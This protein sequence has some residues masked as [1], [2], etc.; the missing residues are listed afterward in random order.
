MAIKKI[1]HEY[2]NHFSSTVPLSELNAQLEKKHLVA[3]RHDVDYDIDI[4]LEMSYWEHREGIRATFFMLPGSNYWHDPDLIDKILQIQDFGH[5]IGVHINVLT[6]WM[7]GRIK[8]PGERLR[9]VLDVFRTA[10]IKTTGVSAH[11][12]PLCYKKSYNNYWIFRELR[13]DIPEREEAGISAEGIPSTGD[14]EPIIYP[15]DH[16]LARDNGDRLSLWSVSMKALE[17]DY[18]AIHIPH[19]QYFSDS[20]GEWKRSPNPLDVD[21]TRGRHQILVHP[22]YWRGTQKLFFFLSTARSGS[23]WLSTVL[24]KASSLKSQHEF[25][26]NHRMVEGNI[27]A[28]KRTADG[29]TDLQSGPSEVMDLLL[30][31][32]PWI[33]EL[34]KDYAEVNVYLERFLTE[35][36]EVFPEAVN[37]HLH[38]HPCDVVRSII[39]RFWYDTPEDNR[40]PHFSVP[41]WN[42]LSQFQQACWYART[43]NEN[44][45]KNCSNRF[46]FEKMVSKPVELNRILDSLDVAFYP[47]LAAP[48]FKKKINANTRNDFPPY[49]EWTRSQRVFYHDTCD[50][51]NKTL[52]YPTRHVFANVLRAIKNL[53]LTSC[54]KSFRSDNSHKGANILNQQPIPLYVDLFASSPSMGTCIEMDNNLLHI[55][56][57][58]GRNA[59]LLFG[60]GNWH[61]INGENGWKAKRAHYYRGNITVKILDTKGTARMICLM[62]DGKGCLIGQRPLVRIRREKD[63]HTFAFRPG[64]ATARFNIAL[65]MPA[66]ELPEEITVKSLSLEMLP[67]RYDS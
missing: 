42:G 44:L 51:V 38:R 22:E 46:C 30:E 12:D 17:L 10:G 36:A 9:Q 59:Y 53:I 23:K 50:D 31:M 11:G 41:G 24:D 66:S 43:V 15:S 16:S 37:V 3:L 19:D 58:E 27:V 62:Y 21:L 45:I 55:S 57:Q 13:P 6:E 60:G 54:Q 40:H 25:L 29:F 64:S 1:Y 48:L 56:P 7:Q 32:R 20:G 26:L 49:R 52:G 14:R 5:E 33:E 39:N 63:L 67:L 34:D 47:R 2:L 8:D 61:T 35:L 18:H 28:D 65:Y 4:A